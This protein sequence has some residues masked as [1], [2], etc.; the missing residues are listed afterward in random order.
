M[1]FY[2]RFFMANDGNK[3]ASKSKKIDDVDVAGLVGVQNVVRRDHNVH[4]D[5][6]TIETWF[7]EKDFI[8]CN[9]REKK[10]IHFDEFPSEVSINFLLYAWRQKFNEPNLLLPHRNVK[11]SINF[12]HHKTFEWKMWKFSGRTIFFPKKMNEKLLIGK[13]FFVS[14]GKIA[15]PAMQHEKKKTWNGTRKLFSRGS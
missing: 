15:R 2:V 6:G 13:K 5:F 12:Q 11:L 8:A 4:F 9:L 10:E 1:T 14:R 3:F 7:S